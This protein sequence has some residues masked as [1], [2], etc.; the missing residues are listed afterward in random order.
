MMRVGERLIYI[1][2][3]ATGFFVGCLVLKSGLNDVQAQI[4]QLKADTIHLQINFDKII[5]LND[6]LIE[7]FTIASRK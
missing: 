6:R 4:N 5:T 3:F 1:A 2:I 7:L